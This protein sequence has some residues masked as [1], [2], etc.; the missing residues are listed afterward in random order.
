MKFKDTKYFGIKL[1][2]HRI[3]NDKGQLIVTGCTFA[4]TGKQKYHSSEL[5][6]KD[7]DRFIYID[8]PYEE[9]KDPKTVASFEACPVT[10]DHPED[11]VKVGVNYDKLAKGFAKNV[12]FVDD[13]P[14]K[15]GHLE[16]DFVFTDK[17]LI[18][19]IE[20]HEIGELSAGYNCDVDEQDWIQRHIRGN[21]IAVVA[22][23]RAGHS[24]CLRDS[25]YKSTSKKVK[26][27]KIGDKMV[28]I[29]DSYSYELEEMGGKVRYTDYY[30]EGDNGKKKF[31]ITLKDS[32]DKTVKYAVPTDNFK[33]VE[34]LAKDCKFAIKNKEEKDGYTQFEA[35]GDSEA[36]DCWD[37]LDAKVKDIN[38]HKNVV[39]SKDSKVKD[40]DWDDLRKIRNYPEKKILEALKSIISAKRY[41]EIKDNFKW[42]DI[43]T[44]TKAER[45]KLFKKLDTIKDS[46]VKDSDKIYTIAGVEYILTKDG[47]GNY[48]L[49]EKKSKDRVAD[50]DSYKEA[51]K[52]INKWIKQNKIDDS[53][54]KDSIDSSDEDI[55]AKRNELDEQI[56]DLFADN[57]AFDVEGF[58][59]GN[60]STEGSIYT[61]WY[62]RKKDTDPNKP[63]RKEFD[64]FD[65]YLDGLCEYLEDKY[66]DD[67]ESIEEVETV[68]IGVAD[69]DKSEEYNINF[70]IY[71]KG[72][73]R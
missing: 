61:V 41:N 62:S 3:K 25:A 1:S 13:V 23:A 19:K 17:D 12:K 46:K 32:I 45:E 52:D 28:K 44:L 6:L 65:D 9:V 51:M 68:D 33:D 72:V 27:L 42:A 70:H 37:K 26:R 59:N 31:L 15:E 48:K 18:D 10:E 16:A 5:D 73:E 64:S 47:Y 8:R 54:V 53:K 7:E 14:G 30:T 40:D 49:D 36:K 71:C 39:V 58:Y 11:D 67:L 20:K 43:R 57:P 24:A 56:S 4:R 22:Q 55:Y 60:D 63:A 21:H 34:K 69:Y 38:K 2:D 35:I 66:L 29:V 50:W